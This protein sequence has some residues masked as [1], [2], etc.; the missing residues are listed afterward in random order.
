LPRKRPEKDS[1]QSIQEGTSYRIIAEEV[2]DVHRIQLA[3]DQ[4]GGYHLRKVSA[5]GRKILSSAPV[6]SDPSVLAEAREYFP[7]FLPFAA[8][9]VD[10]T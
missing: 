6:Y 2:A 8:Q 7:D 4:W 9:P 5:D 1:V 3:E 10:A